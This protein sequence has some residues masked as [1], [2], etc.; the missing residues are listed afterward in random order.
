LIEAKD[1]KSGFFIKTEVF[2]PLMIVIP[3]ETKEEFE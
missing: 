3:F 2:G 1:K